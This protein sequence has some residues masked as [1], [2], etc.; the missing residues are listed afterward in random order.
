MQ[1]QSFSTT[2]M[3]SPSMSVSANT[4]NKALPLTQQQI[5]EGC[6]LGIDSHA[7]MT[8]VGAHA[9]IL[10]IYEGQL[11]NVQPFNDSYESMKNIRTVNAAFAYDS[12]D[13]KTYILEVNQCLDFSHTMEHSLLCPNQARVNGVV[14]EDC[15]KFLDK[16]NKSSH[17]IW[18]PDNN[19][20]LPLELKFPISFLPVRRPTEE[21]LEFCETLELTSTDHWDTDIWNDAAISSISM[22]DDEYNDFAHEFMRHIE[23]SSVHHVRGQKYTPSDLAKLWNIGLS[24]AKRT[25]NQT[26]Q[27]YIRYLD[28]KLSRRVKTLAHQ[29]RYKQLSG[30]LAGFCSDTF[31]SNVESSR[32]NKYMQLF[33][34]RG[35]YVTAYPMKEKAHAHHALDRFLHE[36][37]IPSEMMTDGAR[38]LTLSE[39]GK[40]CVRHKIKQSR[41]EPH[42]PWQN[43]AELGGGI[44]KRK[45][46]HLMK[47][48]ACPVV[49]WDY[50]WALVCHRRCMTVSNN[51]HLEGETPFM[52]VHGYTPDI[53]EYLTCQWYDWV[54]FHEP[55]NPGKHE[56]GRWLGPAHDLGQGLAYHVL[57]DTGQVRVRSTVSP[58]SAAELADPNT[59][60]LMDK[61]TESMESVIGNFSNATQQKYEGCDN[62]P[63][64]NMFE[65]DELDIEDAE[66]QEYDEEGNAINRP[67]LDILDYDAPYLEINDNLIGTKVDLPHPDGEL[68]EATIKLR[69]RAHDGNLIGT[70]NDNPVL[71]TRIYEVEFDDGNYNEYSANVL[72][73]NLYQQI[74]DDGYSHQ[75]LS[76]IIDHECDDTV[77]IHKDNGTYESNGTKKRK[78]T[79]KGWKIKVEW[80]N[81]SS[82]WVPLRIV[83][84]SNPIEMAEY[85]VSRGINVEPAFAWWANY[86]L[87]KRDRIIKQVTHRS[88]RKAMKYGVKIPATVEEAEK[89][90]RENGNS[91]W[92]ASISKELKNVIVAFKLLQDGEVPPVGSKE[93]PYHFIFD[94]KFDLTR[95]ARLVAGGHKHKEVP[96]YASYSSVV[97]RDSVR[98]IFMLAALNN[99]KIKS[100]DIGNAY[101]N[102]PNKERV[103]VKCGKELFGTEAEGNYAVIVRALYGLK[104]AGNAWRHHFS[105][106]LRDVLGYTMT[107]ADNDV[108]MKAATRPDGTKYYSYLV[109]Y[110]DDILCCHHEPDL[111]MKRINGDFRLKGDLIEEPHMYLGNNVRKWN[112][113]N[114]DGSDSECW[115]LGSKTYVAEAMRI[116]EKLMTEHSLSFSST[117]RNGRDTPFSNNLYRPELDSSNYCS[118]DGMTVFQN[119]IGVLRWICKLGRIDIVYE[120]SVLSQYL[121]QPRVGHLQQCLNI[122]YYLKHRGDRSWLTA[123]PTSFDINWVPRSEG[124]I[125]TQERAT[126][127]K[128]LY[129]DACDEVAINMPDPRG[130]EV[131]INVFVDA[132]HAG[133]VITRRSHTGVILMCN[134]TPVQWY[135]KKQNTIETSTFGS[136]FIALRIATELIEALRYKLRM[137]RVKLSGPARVFCDNEAVVKS[138]TMPESRLKKK[139]CSIAYHRCREA[140]AA[141]KL[142]IYYE[143]SETNLADILTKSLSKSKREPLAESLLSG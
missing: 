92:S 138:S 53:S 23:I 18:F 60:R 40:M 102:A 95:K 66:A 137:F 25:L 9:K 22:G 37:G 70:K 42:S 65:L 26:T 116:C 110:V 134:M 99:L 79:T 17:S 74:D 139:H 120:T 38:E 62:D 83:K 129:P 73:E 100:A 126:A 36:V 34:N 50:C 29:N 8:C 67:K 5:E 86:T 128:E 59:T 130:K 58:I 106:Y 125:H 6:R 69:K 113:T 52:K 4:K 103:H 78:I 55:T 7:D 89:F 19:V 48:K 72:L 24:E 133:N 121:A 46:R 140:V 97:S 135:S 81:G 71:D 122:F 13:G 12:D 49:L 43:P 30:Y 88:I 115:A 105:S 90:D 91:I 84:D 142:L 119:L 141:G 76:S 80:K 31:K 136:E 123:D 107:Q 68:K 35:N 124:D 117:K 33:C 56:L 131:D 143:R 51:I 94:V 32:G 41:T 1:I 64:V 44:V 47:S 96:S 15:P 132:D 61:F 109:V 63:Y 114:H 3:R 75:I 27:D 45:V 104:S 101:L 10:E 2:L 112:F 111:I 118:Y 57:S 98:I 28:G 14:I 21:E 16:H 77:A 127:M 82:T 108:Y 39:W 87:K 54:W 20:I 85:A 93:I 11:C